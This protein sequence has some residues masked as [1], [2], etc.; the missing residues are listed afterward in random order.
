MIQLNLIKLM[1]GEGN[2]NFWIEPQLA[3]S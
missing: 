1:I 3:E 2:N